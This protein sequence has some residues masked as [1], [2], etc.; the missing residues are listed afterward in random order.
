MI[1]HRLDKDTAEL[2]AGCKAINCFVND[3][4]DEAVRCCCLQHCCCRCTWCLL[5]VSALLLHHLDTNFFC[6][7][8]QCLN[9]LAKCGVKIISMRCAGFDRIDLEAAA[10]LGMRVVRVPA[11]SPRSVAEHALA[12]I[13]TLARN[14]HL[15]LPRVHS[16]NYTLNGLIGFEISGKTFGIVGTGKIGV[17]LI[18]L[19]QARH[20]VTRGARLKMLLR[21]DQL[22]LLPPLP[23]LLAALQR[24]DPGL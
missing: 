12:L 10:K 21:C 18:K 4:M 9:V 23:A 1:E 11:Y 15:A 6:L 17:E 5:L 7:S 14:L 13:F 22:L 19:L 20:G 2:A 16:G 24:S 8:F 3:D